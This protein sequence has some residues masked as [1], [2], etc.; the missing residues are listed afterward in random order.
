MDASVIGFPDDDALVD[1]AGVGEV[2]RYFRSNDGFLLG[3]FR[4]PVT[5]ERSRNVRVDGAAS[6]RSLS[7][8]DIFSCANSNAMFVDGR[9][10]AVLGGFNESFGVGARYGSGEDVDIVV[11]ARFAGIPI[12]AVNKVLAAHP[13]KSGQLDKYYAGSI[14]LLAYHLRRSGHPVL[15]L[16]LLR[17]LANGL[18]LALQGQ[19]RYRVLVRAWSHLVEQLSG[20]QRAR[21]SGRV[22][23]RPEIQL[24]QV[25]LAKYSEGRGPASVVTWFNHHTAIESLFRAKVALSAFTHI[26][27]DGTLLELLLGRDVGRTSADLVLPNL[28]PRLQ[29]ARIALIGGNARDLHD[30]SAAV[31]RLLRSGSRVVLAIDG[32]A[33]MRDESDIVTRVT[34]ANADVIIIG[35]GAPTQDRIA[36]DL[37]AAK[38]AKLVLTCGGYMDQLLYPLYYPKWAHKFRLGWAVRVAR[39]PRRL[40]K[41]YTVGVLR[42]CTARRIMR[43]A[44]R[45]EGFEARPYAYVSTKRAEVL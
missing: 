15:V 32:Y 9:S 45:R 11:R 38:G 39:E 30:R 22:K 24:S 31:M 3:R 28:L 44:L 40:W 17:R 41:R 1:A 21:G 8:G 18:R 25:L 14:A 37:S 19:I 35:A 27:I 20:V 6:P 23:A 5:G 33:G 13:V 29:N 42:G 43:L 12:R 7:F 26:G 2:L 36:S 34:D 4:D 10:L 16:M